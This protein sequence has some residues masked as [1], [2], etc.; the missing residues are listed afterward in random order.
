[1]NDYELH[2]VS[3]QAAAQGVANGPPQRITAIASSPAK[4]A[5]QPDDAPSNSG[6][7][8]FTIPANRGV[9][10]VTGNHGVSHVTASQGGT[11]QHNQ[12]AKQAS[13]LVPR[14]AAVPVT[15]D[16]RTGVET[17]ALSSFSFVRTPQHSKQ[18]GA[19]F[20]STAQQGFSNGSPLDSTQVCP[21]VYL[22]MASCL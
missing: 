12:A 19:A 11:L 2:V 20:A 8:A 16:A 4:P 15:V 10:P 18:L 7:E 22:P 3:Q 9:G 13:F 14:K 21:S 6:T 5:V 1:M 17:P